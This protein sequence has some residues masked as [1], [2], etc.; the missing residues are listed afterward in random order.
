MSITK[1]TSLLEI[2]AYAELAVKQKT[3]HKTKSYYTTWKERIHGYLDGKISQL[4][5][6]KPSYFYDTHCSTQEVFNI[7][8]SNILGLYSWVTTSVNTLQYL[9]K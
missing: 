6:T 8:I 9:L 2:Q 4:P 7:V 5:H 1:E 3:K